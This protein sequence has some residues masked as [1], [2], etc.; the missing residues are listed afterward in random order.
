M[1]E[2]NDP[3]I[4]VERVILGHLKIVLSPIRC[5]SML[6]NPNNRQRQKKPLPNQL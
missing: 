2:S 3:G 1:K 4:S 6:G 5:T